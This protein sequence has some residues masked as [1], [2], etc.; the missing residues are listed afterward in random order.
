MVAHSIMCALYS[1]LFDSRV[2]VST[3]DREIEEVAYGYEALALARPP[4][5]GS[6]GTQE[7][8][9][10]ALLSLLNMGMAI[11]DLHVCVLY[12][13]SPLLTPDILRAAYDKWRVYGT[14]YMVS[15]QASPLQDIGCFYWCEAAALLAGDPLYE[16]PTMAYALPP[17]RCCDINTPEDWARAE[18]MFDALRRATA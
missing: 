6:M 9:A 4:C 17:E 8:A 3:D 1:E 11:W 12:A 18:S 10:M 7:V 14:P 5:D 16:T 15:V 2:Y 13:T